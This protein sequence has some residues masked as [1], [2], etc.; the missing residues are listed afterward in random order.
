[1]REH[2]GS[3]GTLRFDLSESIGPGG[4]GSDYRIGEHGDSDDQQST[5][6]RSMSSTSSRGSRHRRRTRPPTSSKQ[7]LSPRTG[8]NLVQRS[9]D[10]FPT[11]ERI[12]KMTREAK[13]RVSGESEGD[14]TQLLSM[15]PYEGH[16]M[17]L[18]RPTPVLY[19]SAPVMVQPTFHGTGVEALTTSPPRSKQRA[20]RLLR[21]L[22]KQLKKDMEMVHSATTSALPGL[23]FTSEPSLQQV[24][25]SP[26]LPT[27][28]SPLASNDKLNTLDEQMLLHQLATASNPFH[29]SAP[30]NVNDDANSLLETDSQNMSQASS[31]FHAGSVVSGKSRKKM[32]NLLALSSDALAKGDPKSW[33]K[34]MRTQRALAL[35]SLSTIEGG[36][37]GKHLQQ[38]RQ[39]L[40]D[41]GERQNG[42]KAKAHKAVAS[43]QLA[44]PSSKKEKPLVDAEMD[45]MDFKTVKLAQAASET[46]SRLRQQCDRVRAYVNSDALVHDEFF[47]AATQPGVHVSDAIASSPIAEKFRRDIV[48]KLNVHEQ[49][50]QRQ[51]QSAGDPFKETTLEIESR[52][53]KITKPRQSF[54][55]SISTV[56]HSAKSQKPQADR[57]GSPLKVVPTP[58]PKAVGALFG[59]TMKIASKDKFQ[60]LTGDSQEV[61]ALEESKKVKEKQ[62]GPLRQKGQGRA[63]NVSKPEPTPLVFHES[64]L[65]SKPSSSSAAPADHPPL[66]LDEG[67]EELTS[68]MS[69][70]PLRSSSPNSPSRPP[71][72]PT[73]PAQRSRS[74]KSLDLFIKTPRSGRVAGEEIELEV[75]NTL[76]LLPSSAQIL[77]EPSN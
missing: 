50:E 39:K 5:G 8:N 28:L 17:L 52:S 19:S 2:P 18:K 23:P 22:K 63:A 41:I 10:S 56:T 6:G 45:L 16:W 43:Q 12:Q 11:K 4:G 60:N 38:E 3:P 53:A 9:V 13:K 15:N 54:V 76:S 24:R 46:V 32:Q 30:I 1:M 7:I 21:P 25:S 73:T 66:S 27:A 58:G 20:S 77:S 35:A 44:S 33:M 67:D 72:T 36:G 68:S 69:I 34:M 57:P 31:F 55:S 40:I 70:V 74:V 61:V 65:A 64:S 62:A 48:E 37:V 51:S 59:S 14:P 26:Y 29:P 49:S 42:S 47:L 75:K 71:R